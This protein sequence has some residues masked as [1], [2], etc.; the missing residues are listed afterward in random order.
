VD[1]CRRATRAH[2]TFLAPQNTETLAMQIKLSELL[3]ARGIPDTT[4][5]VEQLSE[6]E[7]RRPHARYLELARAGDR[8]APKALEEVVP[9]PGR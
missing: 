7:L 3:A 8:P 5:A 2:G 1:G 6:E 4:I 9:D